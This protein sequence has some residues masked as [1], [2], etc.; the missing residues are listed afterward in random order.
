MKLVK[1]QDPN[2][3]R[4]LKLP[5]SESLL[6]KKGEVPAYIKQE[7]DEYR[8]QQQMQALKNIDADFVAKVDNFEIANGI[9]RVRP[10]MTVVESPVSPTRRKKHAL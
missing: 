7:A 8:Y 6:C 9:E 2:E 5:R 4:L 10:L 3:R 1:L